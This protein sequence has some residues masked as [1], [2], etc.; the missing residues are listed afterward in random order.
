MG[1]FPRSVFTWAAAALAVA[2]GCTKPEP[3]APPP[4]AAAGLR[5]TAID[6]GKAVTAENVVSVPTVVFGP[7]DTVYASIATEGVS[8][9][10]RVGV[11]FIYQTGQLVLQSSQPI[12]GVG[13]SRA[14][15]H[16]WRDAGWPLG[17]YRVEVFL[18]SVPAGSMEYDVKK[19]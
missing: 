11:R 1:K 19:D 15:F 4:A 7:R 6:V 17:R 16:V 10:N 9:G 14:E 12:T 13:P 8:R 5:I 3:P 2:A 18:D